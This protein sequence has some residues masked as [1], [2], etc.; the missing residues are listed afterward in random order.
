MRIS[1]FSVPVDSNNE[2]SEINNIKSLSRTC[3]MSEHITNDL[4]FFVKAD[5]T[6]IV[7]NENPT[8]MQPLMMATMISQYRVEAMLGG[9]QK[10]EDNPMYISDW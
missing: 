10:Q 9:D 1:T 7:E 2:C 4:L 8:N 3:Q 5:D 6:D